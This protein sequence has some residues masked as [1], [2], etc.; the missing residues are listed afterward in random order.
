MR[1]FLKKNFKSLIV[2]VTPKTHPN[3]IKVLNNHG[4]EVHKGSESIISAYR[5]AL[6]QA[7]TKESE[8]I[9]Y[10]DFDRILHWTRSYPNELKE[11]IQSHSENDFLLIGRTPTAFKTHPETQRET[12]GIANKIASKI[13][14]FSQTR[15]IISVCWRMKP[16]LAEISLQIHVTNRYG[17]YVEWPVV[18]WQKAENP[19]YVEVEG[20]EWET[21]DRYRKEIRE[22]GYDNWFIDFK[23][24]REWEKRVR[25]LRDTVESILKRIQT[26]SG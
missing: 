7:L 11:I 2:V 6:R 26:Y 8:R 10:C 16:R 18:A 5:V 13:L 21:P 1:A 17:F 23:T 19:I 24:T 15:D 4:F 22:I 20:L 25:I 14:R 12:E 9:F 3:I